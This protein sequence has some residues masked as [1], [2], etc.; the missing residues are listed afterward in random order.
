MGCYIFSVEDARITG[1][2]EFTSTFMFT[3]ENALAS[4]E[5]TLNTNSLSYKL[6]L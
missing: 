4:I 2:F 1:W 6:E 3:Y 5:T